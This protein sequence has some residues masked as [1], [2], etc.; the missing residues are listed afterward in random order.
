MNKCHFLGK[1][2]HDPE[3]EPFSNTRVCRFVLEVEEYRKD[4]N[5]SKKKRKDYLD[6]EAWDTAAIAIAKQGKEDDFMVVESIARRYNEDIVFRV[7]SF[8]IFKNNTIVNE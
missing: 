7:T 6:F 8:K 3:T 5:G 1:L 4:K 2:T